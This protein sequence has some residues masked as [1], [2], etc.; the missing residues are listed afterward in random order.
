VRDA[1]YG[2]LLKSRRRL[3]HARIA[4]TLEE[5]FPETAETQPELLA[6]HCAEAGLTEKAVG[7]WYKAGRRSM[8]QSASAEAVTQLMQALELLA[9]LPAGVDRDRQELD[10][11][12][13][14]GGAFVATRGFAAP[15]VG[16]AYGRARELCTNEAHTQQLLAA[17][18]GL[19]VYHHHSTSVDAALEVAKEL[20]HLARR[21]SDTTAQVA[22]HRCLGAGLLFTNLLTSARTPG[23]SLSRAKASTWPPMVSGISIGD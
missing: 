18:S 21:R 9:S 22:G 2:T 7:Y 1:A 12:I 4:A 3:I 14:L 11:Q 23:C 10:L 16:R 15:E 17:M 6:R 5:R 13:A 8:A 19:F 20:L